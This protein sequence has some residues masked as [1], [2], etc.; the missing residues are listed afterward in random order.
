M[1]LIELNSL[2]IIESN[3]NNFLFYKY[4]LKENPLL[5]TECNITHVTS[6]ESAL[7][8]LEREHFSLIL[9]N[10]FVTDCEGIETFRK[11][12]LSAPQSAIIVLTEVVD[13]RLAL[14]AIAQGAEDYL[15][16]GEMTEK[17][18]WR[19]IL[20]ARA[21]QEVKETLRALT[22]TD[23]LSSVY[24]RRGFVTL[25][26][27]QVAL[28]KRLK[29]GFILF[30]ID[31]DHLKEINDTYG[32]LEGDKALIAT[33]ECIKATFRNTDV[34]GRIG[35]DEFAVIAIN[36]EEMVGDLLRNSLKEKLKA[37]NA[38]GLHP[39]TV[40][41]SVGFS[42]FDPKT[43]QSLEKLLEKADFNLY[44]NKK[45]IYRR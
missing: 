16:K 36:T 3:E 10:L 9:L 44:E 35:G 43:P 15:T 23:E 17:S 27:Q 29:K 24:N 8:L 22:F 42:Y 1:P 7:K 26:E 41:F 12:Y 6:L 18:L 34:I 37:Y 21:R 39:Y 32:H 25:I 13:E 5:T 31:L 14:E 4:L 38:R 20:H 40:S 11:V 33:V 45:L 19:A 28:S 2:L 30:L